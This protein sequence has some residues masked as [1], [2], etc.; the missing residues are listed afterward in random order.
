[1]SA[2]DPAGPAAAAV[3]DVWWAMLWGGVAILA[4]MTGL[5]LYAACR[6]PGKRVAVSSR[7]MLIGGGIAFPAVVLAAL[8]LYGL[9]A[10]HALLPLPTCLPLA[11]DRVNLAQKLAAALP[12]LTTAAE[13]WS[14]AEVAERPRPVWARSCT[15]PVMLAYANSP[16]CSMCR[17]SA[18]TRRTWR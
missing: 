14:T 16:S 6:E 4:G 12:S 1:M 5:A 11:S 10:G 15:A 9:R 8:L 18:L 17:W 2:L 3:A 7:V 13:A